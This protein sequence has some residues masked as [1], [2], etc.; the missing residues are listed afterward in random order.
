M[1]PSQIGVGSPMPSKVST[2]PVKVTW[3]RLGL[4]S[5]TICF[6]TAAY[7]GLCH[8]SQLRTEHGWAKLIAWKMFQI[9]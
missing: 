2:R 9:N 1:R 7:M 5:L 4:S 6:M 3:Q 8:D